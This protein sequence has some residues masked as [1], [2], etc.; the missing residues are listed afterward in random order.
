VAAVPTQYHGFC[1]PR[2]QFEHGPPVLRYK[3]RSSP[4][5]SDLHVEQG[6]VKVTHP[7]LQFVQKLESF[8]GTNVDLHQ[9]SPIRNVNQPA[10]KNDSIAVKQASPEV[11]QVVGVAGFAVSHSDRGKFLGGERARGQSHRQL[12]LRSVRE[13]G[14]FK[15]FGVGRKE[16]AF[17]ANDA[18]ADVKRQGIS[19]LNA[20]DPAV[21]EYKDA[22]I[23]SRFRQPAYHFAG[24]DGAAWNFLPYPQ[25]A[26]V[27]PM[28][29]RIAVFRGSIE[30]VNS[31]KLQVA[32]NLQVAKNR[33]SSGQHIAKT[34]Q[35]AGRRFRKGK[36]AGVPAGARANGFGFEQNHTLR[37]IK[38]FQVR[39]GRQPTEATPNYGDIDVAGRRGGLR[40]EVN[41]PRRLSPADWVRTLRQWSTITFLWPYT[42]AGSQLQDTTS[43]FDAFGAP[44]E[45][46]GPL[47]GVFSLYSVKGISPGHPTPLASAARPLYFTDAQ[48]TVD[49]QHGCSFQM[50][51]T[52]AQ[53]G[54]KQWQFDQHR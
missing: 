2:M 25:L 51:L 44:I 26:G 1:A 19:E 30:F 17:R 36:T 18:P 43:Q 27:G 9:L 23:C 20:L 8:A 54:G 21:L 29:R 53:A 34:R 11:R 31:G 12:G 16:Y 15:R 47:N 5:M 28:N 32:R 42:D 4:P 38:A 46:L 50:F 7:V 14:E 49:K 3:D 41:A 40:L 39:G 24:I 45:T 52:P 10:S 13:L 6:R 35:V 33:R 22:A 37:R 48:V